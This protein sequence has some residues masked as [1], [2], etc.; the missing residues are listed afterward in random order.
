MYAK[1]LSLKPP[2]LYFSKARSP[3]DLLA[4]SGLTEKWMRREISN[5]DYLMHLNTIAGRT[6]ND[7]SQYPVFPWVL[8]DY[9]SETLDL[10]NPAMFRDLSMPVGALN[11][12]K[13]ADL[14]ER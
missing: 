13:R 3:A 9:T 11:P 6:Y 10:N 7:L 12:E 2:N 8:S 5:F 4:G 14:K 1:L